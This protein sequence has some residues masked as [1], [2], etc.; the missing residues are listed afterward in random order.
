VLN[1]LI[2]TLRNAEVKHAMKKLWGNKVWLYLI[3]NIWSF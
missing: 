2:Y 3:K 1:P